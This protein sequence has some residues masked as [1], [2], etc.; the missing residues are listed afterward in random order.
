[1]SNTRELISKPELLAIVPLSYP[2]IWKLARED[3]FPRG[4]YI[5]QRALWYLDEVEQW[6]A[7]RPR[8]KFGAERDPID[9][10][11]KVKAVRAGHDAR[12]RRADAEQVV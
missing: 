11:N 5:G 3:M 8:Q 7:D 1:M 2:A 6:L 9:H 4:I 12:R 10:A